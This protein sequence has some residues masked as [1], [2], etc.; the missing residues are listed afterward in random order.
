[1]WGP[2]PAPRPRPPPVPPP[3]SYPTARPPIFDSPALYGKLDAETLFFAYY[4]Q[5]GSAAQLMAARELKRQAWRFHKQ[6]GAWFQ[7]RARRV[8]GR[9]HE[10]LLHALSLREAGCPAHLLAG[11]RARRPRSCAA[12]TGLAC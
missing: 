1:M 7:V 12:G 2:A 9:L 10:L 4:Q 11:G 5:P 3:A 6:H 8:A